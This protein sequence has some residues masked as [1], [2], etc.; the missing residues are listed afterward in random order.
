M[1]R[2]IIL[3]LGMHRC[4][5]SAVGGAVAKL[6]AALPQRLLGA[7]RSNPKGHFEGRQIV[8]LNDQILRQLGSSWD[9][10]RAI[11]REVFAG[12]AFDLT[13]DLA[14]SCIE[15]EFE[16]DPSLMV[17]KDPRICRL[18]PIWIEAAKR[19]G[20]EPHVFYPYRAPSEVASSLLRRDGQDP[21][22][23]LALWARYVLDAE[24]HSRGTR[25]AFFDADDFVRDPASVLRLAGEAAGVAW[26]VE[27]AEIETV[28]GDFV[29]PA[30]LSKT[31]GG[32]PSAAGMPETVYE[33]L[34][35]F[36]SDPDDREAMA[37]FDALRRPREPGP[38]STV[39]RP[40]MRRKYSRP[41][42]LTLRSQQMLLRLCR[43]RSFL[44]EE[45]RGKIGRFAIK[46]MLR[47]VWERQR[48]A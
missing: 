2:K 36:G 18:A 16:G 21:A 29:E 46:R 26:P 25:R 14:V 45:L 44:P 17:I 38:A 20:A 12:P 41:S 7:G 31:A 32:G 11:S 5:T 22:L 33:K 15:S 42:V 39:P 30:L 34:A 1:V 28:L 10:P 43:R 40:Q 8:W 19:L 48:M 6:G 47:K 4:G 3:I 37:A 13:V 9:D 24:Y 27:D 35:R 23:A